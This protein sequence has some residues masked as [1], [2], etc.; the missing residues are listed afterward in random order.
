MALDPHPA[1]PLT[2][3]E[4]AKILGGL[5]GAFRFTVDPET[6]QR[7]LGAVRQHFVAGRQRPGEKPFPVPAALVQCLGG[8]VAAL[9]DMSGKEPVLEALEWWE[10]HSQALVG[11]APAELFEDP[12]VPERLFDVPGKPS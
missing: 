2:S 11:R 6:M 9:I 10:Q 4:C 5:L 8:L 7:L 3:R 12:S 1:R